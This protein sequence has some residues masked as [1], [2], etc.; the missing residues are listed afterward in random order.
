MMDVVLTRTNAC[1]EYAKE[2]ITFTCYCTYVFFLV[3]LC[4]WWIV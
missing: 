2:C 4:W 3:L 1:V